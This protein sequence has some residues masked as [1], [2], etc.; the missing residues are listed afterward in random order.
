MCN[1]E[2]STVIKKLNHLKAGE[3][4]HQTCPLKECPYHGV[5]ESIKELGSIL[6]KKDG[7]MKLLSN[8]VGRFIETSTV[9]HGESAMM[10]VY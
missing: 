9:V 4:N 2:I 8:Q 6:E 5:C 10:M 1:Y 7:E 3:N